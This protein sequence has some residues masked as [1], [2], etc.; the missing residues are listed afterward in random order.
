VAMIKAL[1]RETKRAQKEEWGRNKFR[2]ALWGSNSEL[3]L[4][5]AER[6]E[7]RVESM[8]LEGKLKACQRSKRSLTEQLSRTEENMWAINCQYKEKLNLPASHEQRIEGEHAKVSALQ[9]EK[10]A[11]ERVIDSLHGEAMMWMDRFAFTLNGSQELPRLLAKAKA[12]EDM[13]SA[14]EE[15]HGLFDYCQHMIELMSHIIRNH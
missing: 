9:A 7:P 14:T 10:E 11:R 1:E 4:R 12:M 2:G 8:I 5:R 3:K 15:V 13:Y 6:D